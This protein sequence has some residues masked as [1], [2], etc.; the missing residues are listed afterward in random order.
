MLRELLAY[1]TTPEYRTSLRELRARSEIILQILRAK[2]QFNAVSPGQFKRHESFFS[3]IW[4]VVFTTYAIVT[5]LTK[6]ENP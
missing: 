3:T 1:R 6:Q 2:R 5:E 4:P